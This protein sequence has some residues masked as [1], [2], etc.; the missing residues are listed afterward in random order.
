MGTLKDPSSHSLIHMNLKT[1]SP[2]PR[3]QLFQPNRN[4]Q[5]R[6]FQ[7]A[8]YQSSRQAPSFHVSQWVVWSKNNNNHNNNRPSLH[9]TVHKKHQAWHGTSEGC[10]K[11]LRFLASQITAI[12]LSNWQ[13][14]EYGSSNMEEKKRGE[15][16]SVAQYILLRRAKYGFLHLLFQTPQFLN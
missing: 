10:H 3:S 16:S 11:R 14:K 4:K 15:K 6:P 8:G 13:I 12:K 7:K 2:P 5:G 1:P 9:W